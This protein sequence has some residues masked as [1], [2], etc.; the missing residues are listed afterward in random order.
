MTLLPGLLPLL[1]ACS[2]KDETP[3]GGGGGDGGGQSARCPQ[4]MIE[5]AAVEVELGETDEEQ[6]D[7][8]F[9]MAI[10]KAAYTLGEYCIGEYPL[11][12][13]AG[14]DWPTDGLSI[15]QLSEVEERLATY[16][17]RLCTV[18]ELLYGAAGPENWRHPYDPSTRDDTVCDPDDQNPSPL[19][20]FPNCE[21]PL[22]LH[23]FEV[24]ASWAVLDDTTADGLYPAWPSYFPGGG[25]Y[26][27]YGS[28]S[29][30][31]TFYPPTNFSVHFHDESDDD[32][33][34]NGLRVCADVDRVDAAVEEAWRDSMSELR[35]TG[36]FAVWLDPSL[37]ETDTGGTDTGGTTGGT[38]GD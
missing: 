15:P 21:S 16:N 34:N 24:R 18:G 10:P 8:F 32:Y 29:D 37:E 5:V 35:R 4:G 22:G 31:A 25:R 2:G 28:T 27:A 30:V 14:Q 1:I 6:L 33:I 36:R 20:A 26:V 7:T 11:P 19:G 12:G 17:R 13:F 3:F 9:G 23:D 38:T